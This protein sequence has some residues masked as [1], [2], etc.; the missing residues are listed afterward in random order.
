MTPPT[1]NPHQP[2][3]NECIEP[4]TS[5]LYVRR[6]KAGEFIVVNPHLLQDL[7]ARGLWTLATR[8]ALVA[9]GG[10]IQNIPGVPDDLK[11]IYRTVW[12][13]KQKALIDMAADRGAYIDQ[14]QSLNVFIAEPD[15]SRLTS[16]HF[17]AWKKGLKTGVRGLDGC[18]CVVF[19]IGMSSEIV[20]RAM[21]S[22]SLLSFFHTHQ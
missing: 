8:Q 17:Y 7:T 16:M 14:S 4:Y 19:Q 2:G 22:T 1:P 12:E 3:Y 13:V 20:Q 5:N 10:S 9:E 11:E 18:G 21:Y 15:Y 6:V